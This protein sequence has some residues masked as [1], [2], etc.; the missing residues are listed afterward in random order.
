M[1]TAIRLRLGSINCTQD[2]VFVPLVANAALPNRVACQLTTSLGVC[3][4]FVNMFWQP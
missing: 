4:K 1:S 2:G 3:F